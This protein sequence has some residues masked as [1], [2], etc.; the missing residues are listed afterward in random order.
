MDPNRPFLD[1]DLSSHV[2]SDLAPEPNR[3][4]INS[5]PDPTKI[6]HILFKFKAFDVVKC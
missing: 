5:D 2:Q 3:I 6:F 4:Q 1:S